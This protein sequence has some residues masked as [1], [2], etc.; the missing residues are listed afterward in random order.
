M[1]NKIEKICSTCINWHKYN[2]YANEAHKKDG[3]YCHSDCIGEDESPDCYTEYS[4]VYPFME[5]GKFWT[6]PKF[7][8]VNWSK[9]P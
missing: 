2:K 7:G 5:G 9:K 4:L 8:C 3:G 6:G 1:A